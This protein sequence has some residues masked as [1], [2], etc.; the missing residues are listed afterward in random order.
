MAGNPITFPSDPP[1]E[2]RNQK[3]KSQAS[4]MKEASSSTKVKDARTTKKHRMIAE[5]FEATDSHVSVE[6]EAEG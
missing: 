6:F 5:T 1:P 2:N 4:K 3:V